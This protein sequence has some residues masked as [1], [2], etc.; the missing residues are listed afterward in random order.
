MA[1]TKT[2]PWTKTASPP[3][4]SKVGQSGIM[5]CLD[6]MFGFFWGI[7]REKVSTLYVFFTN[8]PPFYPLYDFLVNIFLV[9]WMIGCGFFNSRLFTKQWI[10]GFQCAT[11]KWPNGYLRSQRIR[12][13]QISNHTVPAATRPL[14]LPVI[15]LTHLFRNQP[16]KIYL[17]RVA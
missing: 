3:P 4:G 15:S 16:T 2:E 10:I 11:Q 17:L 7:G 1:S 9:V 13:I 6:W 8:L 14:I 12:K 5:G